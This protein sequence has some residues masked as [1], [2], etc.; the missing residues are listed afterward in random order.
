MIVHIRLYYHLKQKTGIDR[1][2][3]QVNQKTTIANLKEILV[4]K[5]PALR[6]HLDNIMVLMDQKIVLDDDFVMEGAEI[7]FLTPVGGG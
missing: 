2:N 3:M 4:E 1:F 7:A 6:T 5:Y